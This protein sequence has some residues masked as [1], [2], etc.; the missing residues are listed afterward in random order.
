MPTR[1]TFLAAFQ[2]V[3]NSSKSSSC[4][5]IWIRYSRHGKIIRDVDGDEHSGR[6]TA[7]VPVGFV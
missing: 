6:D 5:E 7:I 2:N 1:N 4:T 3:V